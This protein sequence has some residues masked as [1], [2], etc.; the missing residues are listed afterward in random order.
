MVELG[1]LRQTFIAPIQ[2]IDLAAAIDFELPDFYLKGNLSYEGNRIVLKIRINN[3]D[4]V[5]GTS[6]G[7]RV[8][9][10]F[11]KLFVAKFACHIR[12]S[13]EMR[14]AHSTFSP[15][16]DSS[17]PTLRIKVADEL[18]VSDGSAVTVFSPSSS[19]IRSIANQIDWKLKVA[20]EPTSADLY[21]ARK[22][23]HIG[24]QSADKVARFLILYSA[25]SL[26]SLFKSGK[27]TQNAVDE[28]LRLANPGLLSS[29]RPS[30]QRKEELESLY[31]KLRNDF[32]HAE[33]RSKDP[34]AAR[35]AI[36]TNL[37]AFQKDVAALLWDKL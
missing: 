18:P 20:E 31:T 1:T 16:T 32:V 14:S 7:V 22:L 27:C 2:G 10:E 33:D 5:S 28:L 12:F 6:L 23:F 29:P 19:D 35:S 3:R 13:S 30:G 34:E 25:A 36:E 4:E 17:S 37:A 11:W 15:S 8:A 24:M 9:E 21:T 26:A